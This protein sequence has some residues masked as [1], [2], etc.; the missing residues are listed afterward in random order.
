MREGIPVNANGGDQVIV[1]L[2]WMEAFERWTAFGG[3]ILLPG[4]GRPRPRSRQRPRNPVMCELYS[5][6]VQDGSAHAPGRE[7]GQ[8]AHRVP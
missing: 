4:D 6:A 3:Q 2:K 5:A 8:Y 7:S 1:V